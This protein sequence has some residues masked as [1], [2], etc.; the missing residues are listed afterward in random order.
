MQKLVLK[1]ILLIISLTAILLVSCEK[2]FSEDEH[3]IHESSI[4]KT[5]VNFD[6]FKENKKALNAINNLNLTDTKFENKDSNI[7]NSRT[8]D[9][10]IILVNV[11]QGIQRR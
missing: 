9:F 3:P 1:K 8:Y 2:E 11:H 10:E 5:K 4:K 7:K 6:I